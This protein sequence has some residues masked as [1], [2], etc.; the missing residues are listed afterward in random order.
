MNI[1]NLLPEADKLRALL[2]AARSDPALPPRFQEAVW[3]R[4]ENLDSPVRL[5]SPPTWLDT[6]VAWMLRPQ[7]ALTTATATIVAGLVLG[8]VGGSQAARQQA[9]ARYLAAVAPNPLR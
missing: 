3:R 6:V 9:Q 7:W 2:C 4:I 8:A 5:T 1:P